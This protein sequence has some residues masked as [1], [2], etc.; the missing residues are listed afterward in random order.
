MLNTRAGEL[1]NANDVI[2]SN[3]L[4]KRILNIDSR[5]RTD[6]KDSTTDFSFKFTHAYKNLIRLR[7]SSIEIPNAFYTFTK[8]NNSFTISAYDIS[9]I[10]REA[11]ITIAPG[12]YTAADLI[13]TLQELMNVHMRDTFGIYITI[14]VDTRT[15]KVTFIHEGVSPYP[16]PCTNPVPTQPGRPFFLDFATIDKF[17][18]R[19]TGFGLGYNLGFRKPVYKV[20]TEVCTCFPFPGFAV[21]SEGCLDVVGDNYMFLSINDLHTVEQTTYGTYLQCLAKI[22][23][24]EEKFSIIYDDGSTMMANEIIFP[25]PTDLKFLQVQLLDP[26]GD[27]VDLNGMNFSFSIEITEVLNTTLYDFYR[28]YIW[29][30]GVPTVKRPNGSAMT[31]LNGPR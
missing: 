18:K 8:W 13:L 21:I 19:P 6:I 15:A 4:R 1:L 28:N 23:I 10:L 20:A 26:Y 22:I 2:N 9:C 29:L 30:G 16:V 3:D 12:N 14:S 31:L 25:S 24:R 5:F 7:I 17:K 11:C 27:V